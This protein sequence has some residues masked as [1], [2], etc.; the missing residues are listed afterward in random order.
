MKR[1][2]HY[3]YPF[4]PVPLE[5]RKD[6][7]RLAI[8]MAAFAFSSASLKLGADLGQ[9]MTFKSAV[10]ASLVG[11]FILF[12]IASYW[13][14][15]A[16]QSGYTGCFIVK[17]YLGSKVSS[18]FACLLIFFLSIWIGANGD[19]LAKIFLVVF[20]KWSFSFAGT[21]FLMLLTIIFVSLWGW[22]GMEILGMIAIPL[23]LFLVL[24]NLPHSTEEWNQYHLVFE[25]QQR[26]QISFFKA[27][28]KVV[29][30]FSLSTIMMADICRFAKSRKTVLR[31]TAI[32]AFTLF[33]CDL[34]GIAIV[35][36]TGANN[37][38][39]GIYMLKMTI[40][41]FFCIMLCIYTTQNVNMY[42]ASFALQKMIRKTIMGGNISY[43]MAVLFIGG[44]AIITG[45][46]GVDRY[47]AAITDLFT[48][49]IFLLTVVISLKRRQ[50]SKTVEEKEKIKR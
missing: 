5:K 9:M 7:Y 2:E 18:I 24:Q 49:L 44:L 21:V 14:I 32:Y 48:P 16:Q 3:E 20:P 8:I 27:V 12:V 34:G 22:K 38:E 47:V 35:Q 29:G 46:L 39:Y 28:S 31:C 13:G 43:Q 41:G 10:T 26:N 23:I 33:L 11:N 36:F 1:T 19:A 30:N 15:V 40:S 4:S 25:F 6:G 42:V 37:L 45:I 17:T 50:Q